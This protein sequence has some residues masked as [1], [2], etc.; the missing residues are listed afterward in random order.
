MEMTQ[1]ELFAQKIMAA[2]NKDEE[3]CKALVSC[4]DAVSVQKVLGAHGIACTTEDVEA[5]FSDGLQ[6]ILKLQE[7]GTAGELGENDL[8]SVAGGGAIRGT[9]RLLASGAVA[10]GYGCLC[11]VCPAASVAAPYVGGGLTLWTAAGYKKKGW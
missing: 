1:K 4:E 6:S 8:D 5:I 10:F 7:S 11:G 3:F 2:V 9:L